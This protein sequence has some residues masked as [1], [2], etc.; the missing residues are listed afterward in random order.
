MYQKL[1]SV[2]QLRRKFKSYNIYT[3]IVSTK[4]SLVRFGDHKGIP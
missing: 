2:I 1:H 4:L 3:V